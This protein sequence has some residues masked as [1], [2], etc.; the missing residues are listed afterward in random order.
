[1]CGI[2]GAIYFNHQPVRAEVIEQMADALRHRGPDDAGV[3][4]DGVV[5]LGHRRLK[6]IDLS[7]AGHQPMGNEDGTIQVTYNGEIYNFPELR[8]ELVRR[9]HTFSSRTDTEVIVHAYEEWGED[10]AERFNGMFA[11]GLWDG[12]QKKLVLMRDRL[13]VKPLFYYLDEEKLLFASE[14]KGIVQHP[15]ISK[16]LDHSAIYDYFS[17]NYIPSPKTPFARIRSLLP[18]YSLTVENGQIKIVQYWDVHFSSADRTRTEVEYVEEILG[19][20]QDAVHRRLIADVPLGGFLSGGLDSSAIVYFMN[21]LGHRPLKT[22]NVGFTEKSYDESPHARLVARHVGTEHHEITCTPA[23]FRRLLETIAWHADNLTADISMVPM[24]LLAKLAREQV[25]V[26]LSG[27][28]GDELF[29]GYLTYQA[30]VLARY[31]RRLPVWLRHYLVQPLVA[32]LPNSNGKQS[33]DYKLK[34][35]IEGA[36]LPPDK[37]HY[38]WRTIFS[39]MEKSRVLSDD[40]LATIQEHDSA[41]SYRRYFANA[42]ALSEMDKIFYSDFKVFLADSILAKVDSMTMAHSLEAREPLL[43][44]RLVELSASIPAGLKIKGRETKYIFKTAM[45]PHLPRQ[46]VFRNKEGFHAPMASWFRHEL[47]SFV[48]EVL[49]GENL[50]AVGI[51]NLPYIEELKR[52][53]FAG[54]ENNAFKLWGLMNL[55]A[56]HGQLVR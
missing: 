33:L 13:G 4:V 31:Y 49:S 1:M 41:V 48:S 25:T 23:D 11:F 53:H 47:R 46:I 32:A 3:F 17:L 54:A 34:K 30:D 42:N 6:I 8:E 45:A 26:V 37:A 21:R 52:R 9:G 5:G 19:L 51:F 7:P 27:D 56:W 36:E 12:R 40:F 50:R 15:E 43:D 2:V 29:G 18:G 14:I 20:I 38:T 55:I 16:E 44:Y 10:C 35:F 22:F 28:G 24:Y 39:D